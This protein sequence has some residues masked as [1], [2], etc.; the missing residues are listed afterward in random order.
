MAT[1]YPIK[2]GKLKFFVNP[3]KIKVEKRS[4]IQELRTM[5][6]TIFQVWPDLPDEVSFE[7]MSYGYRSIAEL[8]GLQSQIQRDP[9]AKM[10][11]LVYKN[12]TYDIYIRSLTVSAD[13]DNPRQFSYTISCVCKKPFGLDT[14]PIGQLPGIKAEF[15]FQAAQLRTATEAIASLPQDVNHNMTAVYGQ[16]FGKTGSAEHGL[17]IFIGRPAGGFPF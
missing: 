14:L 16:I 10:T 11:Q 5:G 4:Q 1:L 15:D 3:T 7:G 2:I 8:R 13:A 9:S 17:G 6:G 12:R